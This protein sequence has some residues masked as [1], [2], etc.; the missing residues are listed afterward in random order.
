MRTKYLARMYDSLEPPKKV[1]CESSSPCT[2]ALLYRDECYAT[3]CS[4]I[5]EWFQ[6]DILAGYLLV[7]KQGVGKLRRGTALF[8][9]AFIDGEYIKHSNNY[10]FVGHDVLNGAGPVD[11]CT[12]YE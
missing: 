4:Q 1:R 6:V 5:L 11:Q 10:G 12:R 8:A 7:L 9:E 2:A 3:A